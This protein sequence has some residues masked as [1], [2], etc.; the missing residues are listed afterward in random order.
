MLHSSPERPQANVSVME[1]AV[2]WLVKVRLLG[3]EVEQKATPQ[4]QARRGGGGAAVVNG[5]ERPQAWSHSLGGRLPGL[6]Q[7]GEVLLG[8]VHALLHAPSRACTPVAH[9]AAAAMCRCAC[10]CGV[11]RCTDMWR[12]QMH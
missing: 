8:W 11:G 6:G 5:Q 10:R 1:W 12:R 7:D 9:R 4:V 2:F 3:L